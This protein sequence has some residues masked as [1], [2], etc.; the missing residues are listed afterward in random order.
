MDGTTTSHCERGSEPR[1]SDRNDGGDRR[2]P[3]MMPIDGASSTVRA[4]AQPGRQALRSAPI[5]PAVRC[6]ARVQCERFAC[7]APLLPRAASA[8]RPWPLARLPLPPRLCLCLREAEAALTRLLAPALARPRLPPAR[9]CLPCPECPAPSPGPSRGLRQLCTLTHRPAGAPS[10]CPP[11]AGA[12]IPFAAPASSCRWI[13]RLRRWVVTK[14]A[15]RRRLSPPI[16]PCPA[17]RLRPRTIGTVPP[18]S[19]RTRVRRLLPRCLRSPS[20]Q[21]L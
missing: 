9:A 20:E 4:Y 7:A 2:G 19:P 18:P 16:R 10:Y 12:N 5:E 6:G 14:P 8:T 21:V 3:A 17:R 15:C 13:D 11:T 1:R